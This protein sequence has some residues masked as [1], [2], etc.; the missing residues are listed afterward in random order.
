MSVVFVTG[1]RSGIGLATAL[2]FARRGDTV[3]ATMRDPSR[4]THLSEVAARE[5]LDLE[6]SAL[7]VTDRTAVDMVVSGLIA[8]HGPIDVLVNNAGTG[9]VATAIEEIDEDVARQIVETNLWGPFHLIRAV[10]PAMREQGRGVIVNVSSITTRFEGQPALALYGV[11][12]IALSHLSESLQAELEGSGIRVIAVE[13]GPFATEIYPADRLVVDASS[14]YA[15]LVGEV[16]RAIADL[17]RTAEDPA[18]AADEIVAL[19]DD[20]RAGGRTLV[21]AVAIELVAEYQRALI[22]MWQSPT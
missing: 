19:V 17:I 20:P 22:T 4:A 14:P 9:G 7:D 1:C 6:C 18:V 3:Y 5:S 8:R 10:L 11:S 21:G 16:D 13:P 15:A 12:K 2:A